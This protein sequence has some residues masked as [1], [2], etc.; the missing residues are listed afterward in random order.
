MPPSGIT[1]SRSRHRRSATR[2]LAAPR[3]S[4]ATTWPCGLRELQA[5][6]ARIR[7]V[8]REGT[9]LTPD[10]SGIRFA[11]SFRFQHPKTAEWRAGHAWVELVSRHPA[12]QV[13]AD[14]DYA[15][16]VRRQRST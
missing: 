2:D 6:E 10:G 3:P 12:K 5:G 8:P 11:G 4:S 1:R 15:C 13:D 14:T 7:L 16:D 9:S